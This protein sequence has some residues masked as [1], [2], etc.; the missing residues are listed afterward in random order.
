[1]EK[2]TTKKKTTAAK[3]APKTREPK[4]A[5]VKETAPKETAKA[6]KEVKA[7]KAEAKEVKTPKAKAP[8]TAA[9]PKPMAHGVGRRKSSI[10][11]VWLRAGK[12]MLTVNGKDYKK[13]FDTDIS[14][15]DAMVPFMVVPASAQLD[16]DVNVVG[17]GMISQAGAV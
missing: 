12:G 11:R 5:P 2:K 7:P 15:M 13:Y 17:G 6:P 8:K 14:R 4:E 1:M 3:A 10:A 9:K 16:V